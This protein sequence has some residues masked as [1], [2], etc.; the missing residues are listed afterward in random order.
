M[1]QSNA[2]IPRIGVYLV[3]A[4]AF[5]IGFSDSVWSQD[6]KRPKTLAVVGH[7]D[8]LPDRTE[9]ATGPNLGLPD[10]L[11]D[12]IA[13]HLIRSKRFVVVERKALR[14]AILERRFGSGLRKS[15][16]DRTLD[17]AIGEMD[18]LEGGSLSGT[19]STIGAEALGASAKILKPIEP[20]PV[21]SGIAEASGAIGTTGALADYNDLIKDFQDLGKTVGA[22]LLLVGNIEKNELTTK[23]V[24]LPYTDSK[25]AVEMRRFE[26]RLRLRL[27]DVEK[28]TVAD[29]TSV[30]AEIKE[31]VLEGRTPRMDELSPFDHLGRLAAVKVLDATFPARIASTGPLILTRGVNEGV[32]AGDVYLIHREGTEVTD[33]KGVVLGRLPIPVGKVRVVKTHDTFSILDAVEGTSFAVGDLA[34]LD[35]DAK[36]AEVA[37]APGSA[38]PP[39]LVGL[40]ASDKYVLAVG[41][42][43]MSGGLGGGAMQET[44]LDRMTD[45][46]IVKLANSNRFTLLER[47][48]VDQIIQE[49]EFES[50]VK[51]G[52]L[53]DRLKR[54]TGADYLVH[55]AISNFYITVEANQIPYIGTV[56]EESK[57]AA[58]GIFRLVDVHSGKVLAAEKVS[59]QQNLRQAANELEA[60]AKLVDDFTLEAARRIV[61]RLFPI[62]VLGVATGGAIYVNRGDDSGIAKGTRFRVLRPGPELRDP[63]T[64]FSFGRSEVE[65]GEI[66][67]V[68]VEP[69]RSRARL[70]SGD[71]VAVGDVLKKSA[72][73][74]EVTR[75]KVYKPKW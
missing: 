22:D 4:L 52:D 16:L 13:E 55:G 8:F 74:P 33:A 51:D 39:K 2:T 70:I 23:A 73:K 21:G 29:A 46:L 28:G 15:Y 10:E 58:T 32:K 59:T 1:R 71:P 34:A 48:E 25:R 49:K 57:G 53:Q 62:K 7:S 41:R 24:E 19:S 40:A 66:E 47:R 44:L 68:G 5:T 35:I 54:L 3:V 20:R 26:A 14:R 31:M 72:E 6:V 45:E 65:I 56:Q 18:K 12:R 42:I 43:K 61:E 50:L 17:K 37:R 11:V 27:I 60:E 36:P 9:L 67:I 69:F 64:G 38:D 30:H 75:S 63:D